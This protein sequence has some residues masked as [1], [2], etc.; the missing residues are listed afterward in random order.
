MK[1]TVAGLGYVGLSLAS[2]LAKRN[3]VIAVDILPERVD[4]LNRR[5]SPLQIQG[6]NEYLA[7]NDLNLTAT[8]DPKEAYMGAEYVIIAVPTDYDSERNVFNTSAVENVIELAMQYCPNATIVIKS[9]VPVGY[10]ATLRKKNGYRNILF[11]PEFLRES[12]ALYDTLYPNR[13]VV[14]CDLKD[15]E[16]MESTNRFVELLQDCADKADIPTLLMGFSEAEAV[17]LF[18]NTYLALRV[19]YFNEMDTYAESKN[20]DIQQII[21]GICLDPRIG[22]GYNNP[23]FG[24]GGYCLPKDTRQLLK[25]YS[26]IPQKIITATVESN[27]TRKDYITHRILELAGNKT[28]IIG[29]FRLVMKNGSGNFRHSSIQDVI[30]RLKALG[31]TVIIYEPLLKDKK[32]FLDSR[33]VNDLSVFKNM[34]K[35]IVANRYDPCLDDVWNKVYTRDVFGT[36]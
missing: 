27:S 15:I 20:L 23:S 33:I 8:V 36:N 22:S 5:R 1:I 30:K 18:S 13:I 4:C 16:L 7:T 32:T 35:I 10:T 11:C 17:K 6:M 21:N 28:A 3:Q 24:Y 14:G 31:A 25:N 34:A 29:I 9:T 26:D 19:A 12:N 2:V